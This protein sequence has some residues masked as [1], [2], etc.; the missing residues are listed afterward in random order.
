M[1]APAVHAQTVERAL[2]ESIV[3]PARVRVHIVEHVV[4]YV[5]SYILPLFLRTQNPFQMLL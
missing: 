5:S 2:M 3:I 4:A 1:N